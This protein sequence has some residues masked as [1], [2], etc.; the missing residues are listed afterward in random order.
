MTITRIT[1]TISFKSTTIVEPQDW[2]WVATSTQ[3]VHS[4]SGYAT[5]TAVFYDA[6]MISVT[7]NSSDTTQVNAT[8]FQ[9]GQVGALIVTSRDRTSPD[10]DG[11]MRTYT[12][13]NANL[14][15]VSPNVGTGGI[16]TLSFTFTCTH[17]T[18]GAL[19]S[20]A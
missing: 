12:F 2:S 9:Q 3:G 15:S 1:P 10:G 19:V 18:G 8:N 4:H 14:D 11:T 20:Y 6:K 17:P 16:P 13:A 7:V 5:A